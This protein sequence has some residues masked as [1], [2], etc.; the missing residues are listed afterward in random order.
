MEPSSQSGP[1][2]RRDMLRMAAL[3]PVAAAFTAG[4]A[5]GSGAEG[6]DPLKALVTRARSDAALARAVAKAYPGLSQ[7]ATMIGSV[8]DEHASALQREIDRVNPPGGEKNSSKSPPAPSTPASSDAAEK[9]LR[10]AL[11]AARKQAADLVSWAPSNRAGLAGSVSAGCA[12]LL[13]VLR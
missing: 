12:S 8:R 9:A 13:E 7:S 3:V 4:C 5:A 6:P 2:G 1:F 10:E 11:R